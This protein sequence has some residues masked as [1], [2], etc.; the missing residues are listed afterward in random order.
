MRYSRGAPKAVVLDFEPDTRFDRAVRLVGHDPKKRRSFEVEGN[1]IRWQKWQFRFSVQPIEGL[2]LHDIRYDDDGR[3]R[4]ILY[5]AA[6][7]DM[8]VPYG[9]PSPIRARR[10]RWSALRKG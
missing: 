6:L 2:V 5:R 8:V 4:P 9:D 1:L 3:Q 7:S 10:G